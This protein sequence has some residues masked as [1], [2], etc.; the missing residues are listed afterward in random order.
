MKT[1]TILAAA[2]SMYGAKTNAM[3][4]ELNAS[5]DRGI[6]V[7]RNQIKSFAGTKQVLIHTHASAI[8]SD[9]LTHVFPHTV[10][11]FWCKTSDTG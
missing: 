11:Q 4:L 10:V 8:Y 1:S 9:T 6:G 3:A 7:V 5:D 2:R